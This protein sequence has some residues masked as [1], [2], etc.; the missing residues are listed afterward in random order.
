VRDRER[1]NKIPREIQIE[2]WREIELKNI[3]YAN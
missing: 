1:D 2:T 3:E